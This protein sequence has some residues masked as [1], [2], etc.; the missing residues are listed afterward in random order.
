MNDTVDKTSFIGIQ[1]FQACKLRKW[2]W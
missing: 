2:W 1:Y